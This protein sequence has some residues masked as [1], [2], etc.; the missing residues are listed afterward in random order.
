MAELTQNEPSE[1]IIGAMTTVLNTVRPELDEELQKR[2][3]IS[4]SVPSVT[5]VVPVPRAEPTTLY[6]PA[7]SP[8]TR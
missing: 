7:F 2:A 5:S 3:M 6:N 8:E 1:P 4:L